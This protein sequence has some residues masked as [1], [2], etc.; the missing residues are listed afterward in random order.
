MKVISSDQDVQEIHRE[1]ENLK[2]L[3]SHF[4]IQYFDCFNKD[5]LTF[6]ITELCPVS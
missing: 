1:I 6:I 5:F 4:V 2:N 3:K